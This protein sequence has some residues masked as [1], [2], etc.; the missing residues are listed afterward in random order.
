MNIYK[1]PIKIIATLVVLIFTINTTM[2]EYAW[3]LRVPSSAGNSRFAEELKQA[4]LDA[5]G[6]SVDEA[7]KAPA[8]FAEKDLSSIPT[9]RLVGYLDRGY[10]PVVRRRAANAL[11]NRGEEGYRLGY[12]TLRFWL[13]EE[14]SKRD[15]EVRQSFELVLRSF[16]QM[17]AGKGEIQPAT[18]VE[19]RT[20]T[21]PQEKAETRL[22]AMSDEELRW[23]ANAIDGKDGQNPKAIRVGATRALI[24]RMDKLE[25]ELLADFACSLPA[26]FLPELRE[27]AARELVKPR[28][29]KEIVALGPNVYAQF[30]LELM[31]ST[32]AESDPTTKRALQQL[33]DELEH[34]RKVIAAATGSRFAEAT[35]EDA[36][37]R[38][39]DAADELPALTNDIIRDPSSVYLL[40]GGWKLH[41]NV[42]PQHY[43]TVHA[44]LWKETSVGYEH[45]AAG[46][47]AGKDFSLFVGPKQ[48]ADELADRVSQEIGH[49]LDEPG[50][51]DL[52]NNIL[53]TSKV[54]GRFI[55]TAASQRPMRRVASKMSKTALRGI[56]LLLLDGRAWALKIKA[57]AESK[58]FKVD[59]AEGAAYLQSK[60]A[61]KELWFMQEE[62]RQR[63]FT[64][65]RGTVY[66]SSS[67][68]VQYF[69]GEDVERLEDLDVVT[70]PAVAF[71]KPQEINKNGFLYKHRDGMLER[72]IRP[73]LASRAIKA[74][75][76]ASEA[77]SFSAARG[78][79][80]TAEECTPKR[81]SQITAELVPAFCEVTTGSWAGQDAA[82]HLKA[83]IQE[84]RTVNDDLNALRVSVATGGGT[85][86]QA[87]RIEDLEDTLMCLL[88]VQH[89]ETSR[90]EDRKE[91]IS[92]ILDILSKLDGHVDTEGLA[93]AFEALISETLGAG[94]EGSEIEDREMFTKACETLA[95]IRPVSADAE[96]F[97]TLFKTALQKDRTYAFLPCTAAVIET[98]ES[99]GLSGRQ[100]L[101][102]ELIANLEKAKHGI[103]QP[104]SNGGVNGTFVSIL[105]YLHKNNPERF[106]QEYEQLKADPE[107]YVDRLSDLARQIPDLTEDMM[108]IALACPELAKDLAMEYPDEMTDILRKDA[109]LAKAL[110]KDLVFTK[111]IVRWRRTAPDL[112]ELLVSY[113]RDLADRIAVAE[114]KAAVE[115]SLDEDSSSSRFAENVT[116]TG[117]TR[118]P[119]RG[120]IWRSA[121]TTVK[122]AALMALAVLAGGGC[123]TKADIQQVVKDNNLRQGIKLEHEL[124]LTVHT[125]NQ[126]RVA[127][128]RLPKGYN[129]FIPPVKIV[130]PSVLPAGAG[131]CYTSGNGG[132]IH[133]RNDYNL[134]LR[135]GLEIPSVLIGVA[136]WPLHGQSRT[137]H[138]FFH[139]SFHGVAE[140][141]GNDSPNYGLARLLL[142]LEANPKDIEDVQGLPEKMREFQE[143]WFVSEFDANG[144]GKIDIEDS[145]Y[146]A[147]HPSYFDHNL[148]GYFGRDDLQRVSGKKWLHESSLVKWSNRLPVI[149][150]L[151]HNL[152]VVPNY[153]DWD[154][155][156][157]MAVKFQKLFQRNGLIHMLIDSPPEK[158][159]RAWAKFRRMQVKDPTRAMKYFYFLELMQSFYPTEK[160]NPAWKAYYSE[161]LEKVT[162]YRT[163]LRSTELATSVSA[164]QFMAICDKV[165]GE[166][167]IMVVYAN[168]RAVLPEREL[169]D[170]AQRKGFSPK[171][172][173]RLAEE[174]SSDITYLLTE[175]SPQYFPTPL[176]GYDNALRTDCA[177][178]CMAR[179]ILHQLS[180]HGDFIDL[181]QVLSVGYRSAQELLRDNSIDSLL[182]KYWYFLRSVE[183]E[184]GFAFNY[185]DPARL[186]VASG[187]DP[188]A[189]EKPFEEKMQ[190]AI[191]VAVEKHFPQGIPWA[192]AK[193][194]DRGKF[195]KPI[196]CSQ[197]TVHG[198][199]LTPKEMLKYKAMIGTFET[200]ED[201][202]DILLKID[203]LLYFMW[204]QEKVDSL[205]QGLPIIQ[206]PNRFAE[207]FDIKTATIERELR[208]YKWVIDSSV[209]ELIEKETLED[210]RNVLPPADIP[211]WIK[212]DPFGS[213]H[214]DWVVEN[215]LEVGRLLFGKRNGKTFHVTD[216]VPEPVKEMKLVHQGVDVE[217]DEAK[218]ERIIAEQAK[219]GNKLLGYWHTHPG[220]L[221][222]TPTNKDYVTFKGYGSGIQFIMTT[223]RLKD[224]SI[225]RACYAVKHFEEAG[226]LKAT[227]EIFMMS[228]GLLKKGEVFE[229]DHWM[230]EVEP[231]IQHPEPTESA[232]PDQ[233]RFAEKSFT[234]SDLL[235]GVLRRSVNAMSLPD[236]EESPP[237]RLPIS[238]RFFNC[239]LTAYFLTQ[240]GCAGFLRRKKKEDKW[241]SWGKKQFN[242]WEEHSDE[243]NDGLYT[244]LTIVAIK[245]FL[246]TENSQKF[247]PGV[248]DVEDDYNIETKEYGLIWT[249]GDEKVRQPIQYLDERERP[250]YADMTC[251]SDGA[252]G[253]FVVHETVWK[254]ADPFQKASSILHE[255]RHQMD[256]R[257]WSIFGIEAPGVVRYRVESV[258]RSLLFGIGAT[259]KSPR[260]HHSWEKPTYYAEEAFV[261]FVDER[262]GKIERILRYHQRIVP[263]KPDREMHKYKISPVN[264]KEWDGD[265][266]KLPVYYFDSED[267]QTNR[268][269]ESLDKINRNLT[270]AAF[271]FAETENAVIIDATGSTEHLNILASH[272]AE[273]TQIALIVKK[274]SEASHFA[275]AGVEAFSLQTHG[276][277]N[278]AAIAARNRLT[279]IIAERDPDVTAKILLV[280]ARLITLIPEVK[281]ISLLNLSPEEIAARLRQLVTDI[282][283]Q[284]L[285]NVSEDLLNKAILELA[286]LIY[287]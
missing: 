89:R 163:A 280:T 21:R 243:I 266:K 137:A 210:A 257:A 83:I 221:A 170:Y 110:A 202:L 274:E 252:K 57:L 18:A 69:E 17:M 12:K 38:R 195:I 227:T 133:M 34:P 41:L 28:R 172:R 26:F 211:D 93:D 273:K 182:L 107:M 272:F 175:D 1:T 253:L 159:A 153:E 229:S 2:A 139:E 62:M 76:M 136:C 122:I 246:K 176:L 177:S 262:Y 96:R 109:T 95:K 270:Q 132:E 42:N 194:L 43:E 254:G 44:W 171:N 56:P 24:S 65:L 167:G 94:A 149:N 230:I 235:R 232:K 208:G 52:Q 123:A 228:M 162:A 157:D 114:S 13:K 209:M 67:I 276:S 240:G 178:N 49:L 205:N 231:E 278:N 81:V 91:Y 237:A 128:E 47:E 201:S 23:Y 75:Q 70:L 226:R 181:Y 206:A 63:A 218:L 120:G 127:V 71:K 97:T 174:L 190:R 29:K 160:I 142:Q 187:L 281:L 277:F 242:V 198:R 267:Q 30:Y 203:D 129:Q 33:L 53:L 199:F 10:S 119:R 84:V 105:V 35:D 27:A 150:M 268:F 3:A 251:F 140:T 271:R 169:N 78:Y 265:W 250:Y 87:N 101:A 249:V 112:A 285:G 204:L 185:K 100:E 22:A 6:G 51:F 256:L 161:Q 166:T 54:C 212:D 168:G 86:S 263:W 98:A 15:S 269:A 121:A 88:Q 37:K 197:I 50:N 46:P 158:V 135:M 143:K 238:R 36:T 217:M 222:I 58:G 125:V 138:T 16:D 287:S 40:S 32:I 5:D 20:E 130:K 224:D 147:E 179:D 99:M 191:S 59:S 113:N 134:N 183:K 186:V 225:R 79:M 200:T 188:L 156:E 241:Y 74:A 275:D 85:I 219:H 214:A 61:R 259:R 80:K 260:F 60:D 4:I 45:Y 11:L 77:G 31:Q 9:R 286:Y 104:S 193:T 233:G 126:L 116:E 82:S 108:Q 245:E 236:K 155:D 261:S 180:S 196:G 244:P 282:G 247:F 141:L 115:A 14:E 264:Y 146:V 279:G 8:R 72:R 66:G 189:D 223:K 111:P 124:G 234:R 118:K 7:E 184:S 215:R 131:A 102:A 216:S 106:R 213:E 148:D 192:V 151:V 258:F 255:F 154:H 39:A 117:R 165:R 248:T 145:V 90:G 220:N 284:P 64:F 164:E 283:V 73:I 239:S 25:L 68:Y 55:L 19:E 92:I 152:Y 144:D 173:N 48:D 207:S 103:S